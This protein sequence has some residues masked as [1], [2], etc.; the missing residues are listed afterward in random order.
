MLTDYHTSIVL[1]AKDEDK[2][3]EEWLE[4][5]LI[6]GIDHFYVY[7]NDSSPNFK[8]I[9]QPYI[10][11]GIITYHDFPGEVKQLEA[12]EHAVK[13]YKNDTKYMAF[14][15]ADEFLV[16]V[17]GR[18]LPN[19][20][21]EIIDSYENGRYKLTGHAG[22][23]GVNWR[24]YGTSGL[25]DVTEE[26]LLKSHLMRTTDED[27]YNVHIKTICNPRVVKSFAN[28]PHACEY[29]KGYYTI[30]ENGSY[31]P[32]AF[33]FDSKCNKL[34]INHYFM[35]SEKEYF[36]KLKR[37]WPIWKHEELSKEQMEKMYRDRCDA[38]NKVYDDI[39]LR[40]SDKIKAAID[41][42]REKNKQ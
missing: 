32:G 11:E 20:I 15:D 33:F 23:I 1:I 24:S 18:A 13:H 28:T 39:M 14:I 2:D 38:G 42:R 40:Y 17:D 3:I 41:K 9:L 12:Y 26:L 5:H 4:Y 16:S 31:I 6:A 25:L 21:D 30:S 19:I 8:K 22:G 37:G 34:R 35:K 36:E 27:D 29:I 7:D 10:D